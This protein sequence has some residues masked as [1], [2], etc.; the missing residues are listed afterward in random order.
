[1]KNVP[2]LSR[3]IPVI[4]LYA[5][6]H[7]LPI[8]LTKKLMCMNP[9]QEKNHQLK[10]IEIYNMSNKHRLIRVEG[11]HN[12]FFTKEKYSI[13]IIYIPLKFFT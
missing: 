8:E 12:S 5:T 1:M 3:K 11:D 10:Q 7:C 13:M 4:V 6:K 9:S 2:A